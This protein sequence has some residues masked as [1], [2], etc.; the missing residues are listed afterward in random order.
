MPCCFSCGLSVQGHQLPMGPRCDILSDKSSHAC[1][2]EPECTMCSQPWCSHPKGKQINK[3]CEFHQQQVPGDIASDDMDPSE[4]N[5]VQAELM[6]IT[7]KNHAIKAQLNQLTELVHQLLLQQPSAAQASQEGTPTRNPH[8]ELLTAKEQFP[9]AQALS[10]SLPPFLASA[11]GGHFRGT[12]KQLTIRAP[13][14]CYPHHSTR[15]SCLPACS[16]CLGCPTMGKASSLPWFTHTASLDCPLSPGS[17]QAVPS[18]SHHQL[19]FTASQPPAQVSASIC[20]KVQCSEYIDLLELLTYDF[21]Y[22][23]SR[24]DDGQMLEIVDGNCH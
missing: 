9:S 23:Y 22:K 12:I 21:Q 19:A 10:L 17:P 3:E 8:P 15:T 7:Q 6:C 4:D 1:C 11:Q 14:L 24:L 5:D 16:S 20:S 13:P 2:L 18:T